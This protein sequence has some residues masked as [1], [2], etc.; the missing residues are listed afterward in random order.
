ME[1]AAP[2]RHRSFPLSIHAGK[3]ALNELRG[4]VDRSR[5]KRA[6]VVCGKSIAQKTDLVA[7]E[8]PR[9]LVAKV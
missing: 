5:A 1:A 9:E 8:D 3:G 2:F 6:F 7:C 4:E